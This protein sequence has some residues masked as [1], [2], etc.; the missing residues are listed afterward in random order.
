MEIDITKSTVTMTAAELA[1]VRRRGL[2]VWRQAMRRRSLY[3]SPIHL[4]WVYNDLEELTPETLEEST[5]ELEGKGWERCGRV[6]TYTPA[7]VEATQ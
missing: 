3:S 1:E 7:A 5:R 6:H 4:R 2:P